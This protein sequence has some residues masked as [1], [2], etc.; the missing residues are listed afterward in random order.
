M[1]SRRILVTG[2]RTW[3]DQDT[4]WAALYE[5]AALAGMRRNRLVVV[6]GACRRGADAMAARWVAG[7]GATLGFVTEEPHPWPPNT[8]RRG[9]ILRNS[10]M[11]NLGADRCLA[12]VRDASPG[13][14]DCARKA[15]AAKIEVRRWEKWGTTPSVLVDALDWS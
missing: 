9:G 7:P 8:G 2:S 13:S 12:F 1:T 5:E 3:D 4:V 11:V 10:H 15:R 14:S 6:H